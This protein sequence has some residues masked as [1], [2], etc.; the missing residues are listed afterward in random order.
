[1][2]LVAGSKMDALESTGWL[3]W[4]TWLATAVYWGL[5]ALVWLTWRVMKRHAKAGKTAETAGE[6]KDPLTVELPTPP[7]AISDHWLLRLRRHLDNR[8]YLW[9][10]PWYMVIGPAGKRQSNAAARGL[11]V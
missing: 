6:E 8:C 2:D 3:R 4:Q 11:S 1:M 10:L 7:A 9:Q 5:I